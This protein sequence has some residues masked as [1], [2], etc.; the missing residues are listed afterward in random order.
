M[1]NQLELPTYGD[2][3]SDDPYALT[4]LLLQYARHN[5][6]SSGLCACIE[7]PF[8]AYVYFYSYNLSPSQFHLLF[9]LLLSCK[10]SDKFLNVNGQN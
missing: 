9:L 3:D 4:K 5:C 2:F 1:S 7:E 10:L 6:G 8:I